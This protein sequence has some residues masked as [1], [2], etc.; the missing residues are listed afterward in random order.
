[1]RQ[2]LLSTYGWA[3]IQTEKQSQYGLPNSARVIS[4]SIAAASL[5]LVL[6]VNVNH[7][8]TV[9]G[10]SVLKNDFPS[11]AL[12]GGMACLCFRRADVDSSILISDF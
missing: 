8:A 4:A 11:K 9:K 5:T 10:R 2:T 7:L 6:F 12:R 1:M 3:V